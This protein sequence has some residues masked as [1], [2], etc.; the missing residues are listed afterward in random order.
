MNQNEIAD[1]YRK[2]G[3]S[4]KFSDGQRIPNGEEIQKTIFAAIDALKDED[5]NTQ[6]E[7]GRLIVKKRGQFFDVFMMVAEYQ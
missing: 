6:L 5:D 2:H 3:Y 4:W 7:V 1:L